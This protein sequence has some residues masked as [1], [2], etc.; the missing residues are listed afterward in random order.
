M[1]DAGKRSSL[2][3]LQEA[4]VAYMFEQEVRN[5][6]SDL[7][8]GQKTKVAAMGENPGKQG[9]HL[10][11]FGVRLAGP[12]EVD[13]EPEVV[14]DLDEQVG[15]V[16]PNL[17]V[18]GSHGLL[19]FPV[20]EVDPTMVREAA[21]DRQHRIGACDAPV[22]SGPFHPQ[23]GNLPTGTLDDTGSDLHALLAIFVVLHL[24]LVG[25]EIVDA[26][27]HGF[28]PVTMWREC[29]DDRIDP[30]GL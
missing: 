27:R 25:G 17:F 5:A 14:L 16:H 26:L 23:P 29:G 18:S 22:T 3:L 15:R 8:H 30:P 11:R 12:E 7:F 24:R 20:E 6:G 13:T 4:P 2:V 28:I 9:T 19:S 21:L 1:N 10:V